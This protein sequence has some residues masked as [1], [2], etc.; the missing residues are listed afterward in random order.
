MK[1]KTKTKLANF[2]IPLVI[3]F[4]C[5]IIPAA[6]FGSAVGYVTNEIALDSS[7]ST[8]LEDNAIILITLFVD[9][10]TIIVALIYMK[11]KHLQ[12]QG[13]HE[14]I[15]G[16]GWLVLIILA[17]LVWLFGGQLGQWLADITNDPMS[18]NY[19]EQLGGGNPG[20]LLLLA[21]VAAPC[22]EELAIRGIA[23]SY[24]R[25]NWSAQTAI[26][27]TALLFALIHGTVMHGYFTFAL[28]I[29]LA[30]VYQRTNKLRN[31][32]F[33][34]MGF[35]TIS[36][37]ATGILYTVGIDL[38]KVLIAPWILG[39]M[40]IAILVVLQIGFVSKVED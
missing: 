1:R 33:I 39:F 4:A 28:G 12:P 23:Y 17:C 20:M 19:Q 38:S 18:L 29:I 7:V 2:C 26:Y 13:R 5:Q 35:N 30:Y 31:C 24:W 11:V 22:A 8:F 36:M 14:G 40:S 27:A 32:I 9:L 21:C 16:Q 6:L 25:K 34:H 15:D 3:F 10:V 37:L